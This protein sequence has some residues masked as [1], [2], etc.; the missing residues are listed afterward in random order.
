M[1]PSVVAVGHQNPALPFDSSN[2]KLSHLQKRGYGSLVDVISAN[3]EVIDQVLSNTTFTGDT[4]SVGAPGIEALIDLLSHKEDTTKANILLSLA[5]LAPT[6][7]SA[8][9]KKLNW[10]K[11][12][13][14]LVAESPVQVAKGAAALVANLTTNGDTQK[15]VVISGTLKKLA[16]LLS[17][18]D[19]II[20]RSVIFTFANATF[21]ATNPSLGSA[22]LMSNDVMG[23]II[24]RL[25]SEEDETLLLPFAKA[26]H[27]LA[28][29]ESNRSSLAIAQPL[30]IGWAMAV[31]EEL[32]QSALDTLALLDA[33]GSG[34]A[35]E[36]EEPAAPTPLPAHL[37]VKTAAPARPPRSATSPITTP[38][39][40]ATSPMT[41]P[42]TPHKTVAYPPTPGTSTNN[43]PK[44]PPRNTHGTPVKTTTSSPSPAPSPAY[45]PSPILGR[46]PSPV[47]FVSPLLGRPPSPLSPT[48]RATAPAPL[49]AKSPPPPPRINAPV[50]FVPP[51]ELSPR[52]QISQASQT[53]PQFGLRLSPP[54]SPTTTPSHPTPHTP[55]HI[56]PHTPHT[57]STLPPTLPIVAKPPPFQNKFHAKP[58][59][60]LTPSTPS[61]PVF[62]SPL[63]VPI[64]RAPSPSPASILQ[65]SKSSPAYNKGLGTPKSE[66]KAVV[67]APSP[68]PFTAEQAESGEGEEEKKKED[69]K[70]DLLQRGNSSPGFRPP[71]RKDSSGKSIGKHAVVSPDDISHIRSLDPNT[72]PFASPSS[73]LPKMPQ[74]APRE[75]LK[76]S[77]VLLFSRKISD[78][79]IGPPREPSKQEQRELRAQQNQLLMQ[80]YQ[81]QLAEQQHK[82]R[83]LEEEQL[84][85]HAEHWAP[86]REHLCNQDLSEQL[87]GMEELLELVKG[88][89]IVPAVLGGVLSGL[90]KAFR[91]VQLEQF[92]IDALYII[93]CVAPRSPLSEHIVESGLVAT[94]IE[95][96]SSLD[97]HDIF[98]EGTI[99]AITLLATHHEKVQTQIQALGGLNMFFAIFKLGGDE[100]KGSIARALAAIATRNP[101][102]QECILKTGFI[103]PMVQ[104]LDSHLP[105]VQRHAASAL[106]AFGDGYPP[107][108]AE[109]CKH[110]ALEPLLKLLTSPVESS[111]SVGAAGIKALASGNPKI[112]DTVKDQN[113]FPVFVDLLEKSSVSVLTHVSG[114]LVELIK[115]NEKNQDALASTSNAIAHLVARLTYSDPNVVQNILRIILI[116]SNKKKK[117]Q[118][119][120]LDASILLQLGRIKHN[121]ILYKDEVLKLYVPKS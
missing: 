90:N 39:S 52:S 45:V 67:I 101:L 109:I 32:H 51:A 78:M 9:T 116:I 81:Q 117:R 114:A 86:L 53:S 118:K 104:L 46:P 30:L 15:S 12:V 88:E 21:V 120:F 93:R 102:L 111:Q 95:S 8:I 49:S 113:Y 34:A 103:E 65:A 44:P 89:E 27:R 68:V 36:S 50:H 100:Y 47:A 75:S 62:S 97:E 91:T 69:G 56:T 80:H 3:K 35:Q 84:H 99:E 64:F 71:K 112:Q 54:S 92:K 4:V 85:R 28:I 19:H 121:T 40:P 106:Y 59:Q 87:K 38:A 14:F 77:S 61:D 10:S 72:E 48:M 13:P 79:S 55:T 41:S 73:R 98:F 37:P 18:K 23:L 70:R 22:A 17:L 74:L 42:T 107:A 2:E 5:S 115:D 57:P 105:E 1:E 60:P 26:L 63:P 43:N 119:Q 20:D 31:G 108:Q 33:L 24:K 11:I 110:G 83:E 66:K 96:L 25:E 6:H 58:T 29:Q 94:L 7:T 16:S 82:Q 76:N